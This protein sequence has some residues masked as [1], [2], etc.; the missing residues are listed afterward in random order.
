ML[1][2]VFFLLN[3]LYRKE[4]LDL[5]F[6]WYS[7]RLVPL[8][9]DLGMMSY[10]IEHRVGRGL[11]FSPVVGIGTPPTPHPQASVPPPPF[12]SEGAH[13]LAREG[14]GRVL[15]PT[16]GHTLWYSVLCAVESTCETY[17]QSSTTAFR[18]AA[19][20]VSVDY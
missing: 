17:R 9:L 12:G 15:I 20:S 6:K 10:A 19:M 5:V 2:V 16:R 1:N 11:S 14:G 3:F 4:N 7:I 13:S 8:T 18:S